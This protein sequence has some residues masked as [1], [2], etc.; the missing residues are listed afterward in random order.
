MDGHK[1]RGRASYNAAIESAATAEVDESLSEFARRVEREV[2]RRGFRQ[3]KR[4]V[5]IGDGAKWI[6]NIAV[7]QREFLT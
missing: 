4:Q 2:N 5:I 3:A 1:G 6:W 7:S